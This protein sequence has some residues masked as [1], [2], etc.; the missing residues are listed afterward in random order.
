[1]EPKLDMLLEATDNLVNQQFYRQGTDTIIGRTPE[2]SIKIRKSGQIIQKF[3]NMFNENLNL[4]KEGKFLDY[5]MLF[6]DI[7]GLDENDLKEIYQDL[8]L[9]L[10]A[11]KG[12]EI[13][14]V[15]LYTVVLSSI[16]TKIR[17]LHFN[18]SIDEVKRRIA[19][20]NEKI[21]ENAVKSAL[22]NLFM[23]NNDNVSLLYNISY[24]DALADT[25]NYKKVARVC[26]IQKSR[27][28]NNIVDLIV[29]LPK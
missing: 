19:L 26:K 28:I 11:L 16:V 23:R 3:K 27:Y 15:V 7:K 25:F 10:E 1:M 20:K 9:R 17:D 2:V 22:D 4:F 5:V 13:D 14:N 12:V 18:L 29:K 21:P 6:K 8:D 24:L